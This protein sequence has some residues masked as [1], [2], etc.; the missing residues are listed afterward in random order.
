MPTCKKAIMAWSVNTTPD[1]PST[2]PVFG[3][4]L[5]K[6]H[7]PGTDKSRFFDIRSLFSIPENGIA[8]YFYCDE[9][10][11]TPFPFAGEDQLC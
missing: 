11:E 6:T 7:L 1:L 8:D 3:K 5:T 10:L 9:N 2:G 4:R